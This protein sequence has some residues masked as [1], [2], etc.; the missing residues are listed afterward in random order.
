M[1]NSLPFTIGLATFSVKVIITVEAF[2]LS[3]DITKY[4]E[5]IRA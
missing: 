4:V 5:Q 3:A 1:E 2:A